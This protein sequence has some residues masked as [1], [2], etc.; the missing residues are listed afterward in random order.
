MLIL[1]HFI[2]NSIFLVHI[3]ELQ[4]SNVSFVCIF[5]FRHSQ[6][7]NLLFVLSS[8]R[9]VLCRC[10]SFRISLVAVLLCNFTGWILFMLKYFFLFF[11][12]YNVS[13]LFP[14]STKKPV[15]WLICLL[16]GLFRIDFGIGGP[17]AFAAT[18]SA[19]GPETSP[20]K[21]MGF[22]FSF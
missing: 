8:K 20:R 2:R 18:F 13:F 3:G 4:L 10:P 17:L 16:I 14:I 21:R 19:R 9:T 12:F 11:P 5:F 15:V 22:V 6:A 1:L 7:A